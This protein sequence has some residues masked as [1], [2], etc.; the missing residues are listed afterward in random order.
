[1]MAFK[2]FGIIYYDSSLG[3]RSLKGSDPCKS[4]P[5]CASQFALQDAVNYMKVAYMPPVHDIGPHLRHVQFTF[6][7]SNQHGGTLHGI[8]FN[9][10]VLPVDNQVPEVCKT[11]GMKDEKKGGPK[12]SK[13][14]DFKA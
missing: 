6:S 3:P 10:T 7:I 14:K 13:K 8:C 2:M 1:M 12:Q 4:A 11:F 9:I 5:T